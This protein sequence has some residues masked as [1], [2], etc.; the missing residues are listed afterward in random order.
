MPTP[1]AAPFP[2]EYVVGLLA[3]ALIAITLWPRTP[4]APAHDAAATRQ[5]LDSAL[6]LR[7]EGK[8][9]LALVAL[10][11]VIGRD[12]KNQVALYN[13]GDLFAEASLLDEAE[14]SYGRALE[15]RDDAPTRIALGL[16]ALRRDRAGDAA[17]QFQR[18][19]EIQPELAIAHLNHGIA[20]SQD[21]RMSE[22]V[23]AFRRALELDPASADAAHDLGF[24]LRLDGHAADAITILERVV[25][26]HPGRA[27]SHFELGLAYAAAGR[28]ADARKALA[29]VIAIEPGHRAAHNELAKLG[30]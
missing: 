28:T 30:P 17:T 20:L 11:E 18:A 6:T 26:D 5:L 13:L 15:L 3:A 16:I 8:R 21:G 25:S 27:I 7:R 1:R 10:G 2:I 12:P 22:A 4:A 23:V 29:R 14:R 9:E 19:T 24:A